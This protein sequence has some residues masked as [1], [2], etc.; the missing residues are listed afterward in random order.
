M[1]V[2]SSWHLLEEEAMVRGMLHAPE[3]TGYLRVVR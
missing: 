2:P 1:V 3:R